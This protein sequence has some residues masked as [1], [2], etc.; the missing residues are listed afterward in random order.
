MPTGHSGT[1]LWKKLGI[2]PGDRLLLVGSPPGWNVPGIPAGVDTAREADRSSASEPADVVIAF[3]A[4]LGELGE[5]IAALGARIFPAGGLWIAWPRRAGGHDSDIRDQDIRD[6]AL[7]LG[8][9]DVKVAA[10][11][12]DWS[13]LRLVW[14]R[15]R[16]AASARTRG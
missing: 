3:F 1:P 12:E 15:E 5:S 6:L 14:R 11:D 13:G 16:R 9:V 10:L 8:L 7:P 4:S 2:R